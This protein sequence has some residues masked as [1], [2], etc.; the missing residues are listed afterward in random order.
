M[1]LETRLLNN[2][3]TKN[4][5]LWM[6]VLAMWLSISSFSS[7]I[8]NYKNA[9]QLKMVTVNTNIKWEIFLLYIF[10]DA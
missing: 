9:I 4:I 1:K 2:R 7:G 8:I 5:N 6:K 3:Q 10:K